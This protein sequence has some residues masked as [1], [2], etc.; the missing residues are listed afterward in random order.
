MLSFL[1]LHAFLLTIAIPLSL[2]TSIATEMMLSNFSNPIPLP[3]NVTDVSTQMS[4][5]PAPSRFFRNMT[6]PG[7][8]TQPAITGDTVLK[9]L[10]ARMPAV[11][12]QV[13]EAD[14]Q[15]ILSQL[16]ASIQPNGTSGSNELRPR[17]SAMRVLIVGDSMT[18]CREGDF[19]WR[20]RLWDWFE[21]EQGIPV[22]FV[23]P[24][25]GTQAPPDPGPP[26]PPRFY[27]D[28]PPAAT[29]DVSGGY[30]A[31]AKAGWDA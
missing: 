9:Q 23:G 7:N 3:A 24:Y 25:A 17:Q 10:A 2:S 1:L 5:V 15:E 14:A 20:Y 26:Q 18:H 4:K 22:Q 28:P 27:D 16:Q 31:S 12:L 13:G 21:S 6:S 8:T 30:S 19:T 29:F 11:P